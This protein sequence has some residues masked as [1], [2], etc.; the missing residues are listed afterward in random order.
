MKFISTADVT[1]ITYEISLNLNLIMILCLQLKKRL[2]KTNAF[3]FFLQTIIL[4]KRV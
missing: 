2:T 3:L 1:N 4:P